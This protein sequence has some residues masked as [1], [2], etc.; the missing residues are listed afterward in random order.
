MKIFNKFRFSLSLILVIL[1]NFSCSEDFLDN[2]PTDAISAEDALSSPENMML[3][4]NGLHRQMYSQAQLPGSSS[5]RSGESHFIP[6]LDAMGGNIIHSSP[7]N[8]WMT[9]DLQW[10]THTNPT[11]T[12]VYN[13][14][15][16]R[17]H[18]IAS[19]NSII[20]TVLGGDFTEGP[21]L[22]NILGQAYAYRAWSYL[23]LVTTYAKGYIIGNPSTDP[24]VPL[25][26]ATASPY[27]SAPRATVEEVYNQMEQDINEAIGYLEN[28]SSPANKSHISLNA[29][30]GIKARIALSKGDWQTVVEAAAL[31]REGFPLLNKSQWL[32]G[33]NTYD[34]SEVIWGGRVIDSETN[35]YQSYF[36]YISPTFNGSQNRSNPKIISSEL[37]NMIPETDYRSEAWLP[38]APNTNP[39]ASNGKGGSYESDPNYDSEDEFWDA[40]SAIINKYG[41]T[42][43]HN[44]HPYMTVKF[45]Q[46]NPGTIDPDDVIY[47]RSSEMYLMEIEALA[48]MNQISEAQE[49]LQEFGESR[50]SAFEA[51]QFATQDELMEQVKFQRRVELWGEGFS[52][53]DH[54]RWD[55]PLD[56]SNSGAAK[57]LYQDGFFQERPSQNDD[58]IWKIPQAEIDANPYISI[59]DQN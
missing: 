33:F 41:M 23:R 19:S 38:L 54:I 32:S 45:L 52:F 18:F 26:F 16:Q 2:V 51:S 1:I 7:G 30:Y 49:L 13:F 28:A 42:T 20:N 25:V 59:S 9:S 22:N 43:G 6:S 36:Y 15:Y 21:E 35:Y 4:L 17:Y 56:Q 24:G 11:Y 8:G 39:S 14:W 57:V 58:W 50:D 44:T 34:L 5:S 40:W 48:M 10:L 37:Y 47:M 12:T 3:V 55:D 53:H 46:K 29:A 31:A 27:D